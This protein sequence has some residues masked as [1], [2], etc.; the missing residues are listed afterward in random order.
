MQNFEHFLNIYFK[1]RS[2]T[3]KADRFPF[4][5]DIYHYGIHASHSESVYHKKT[6]LLLR[7]IRQLL[8]YELDKTWSWFTFHLL[9]S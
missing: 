3:L 7:P 5:A 2:E 6:S 9:F 8:L 4:G 1:K